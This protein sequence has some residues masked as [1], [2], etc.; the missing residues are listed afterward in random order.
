MHIRV[1]SI[2]LPCFLGFF[3]A[4]NAA[5][6]RS[7]EATIR[8][9]ESKWTDAYKQR[10]I[11]PLA[12]LLADDYVITMEDGMTL[13]EVPFLSK[14]M[15]PLRVDVAE[16]LEL[17]VRMRENIAVVTGNYHERGEDSGKSF[18]YTDRFTDV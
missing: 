3:S 12:A 5:Q 11:A 2:S 18:D 7:V 6:D 15:G 17:K 10:R 16:M 14:N 4:Q 1:I 13:S 9:L 8:G